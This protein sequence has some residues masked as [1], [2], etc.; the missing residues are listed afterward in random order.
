MPGTLIGAPGPDSRDRVS[1]A[2]H[3]RATRGAARRWRLPFI[4]AI[5][6]VAFVGL[7]AGLSTPGDTHAANDEVRILAGLPDSID[8]AGHGDLGSAAIVAQLF[9]TLT[10]HDADLVI[11]PA[12]ARGWDINDGGRQVVFRL[13]DGLTFSDGSPLTARDVVRSWRR[14]VDPAAPSPLA[15]LMADVV[16]AEAYLRGELADPERIGIRAEGNTVV[17]DLVRPAADFVSIVSSAPFAVVPPS[18]PGAGD[19]LSAR[20]FIGSGAYVL[21]AVA[22]DG[23]VL[24]ANPRYWAGEPAIATV[25]IVSDLGGR[26]LVT[27]F[28]DGDLDYTPI[29]E[30]DASWIRYN[31]ALGP[32][33]RSVPSLSLEFLG[34]DT[35]RPPFDDVRVRQA[36][37][38]AVNW[39]RIVELATPT[40]NVPATGMVPV[41]IPG[42]SDA[43]F[44]PAHDPDAARALL[45]EAGF[46]GGRGFPA[47][48]YLT[49]GSSYARAVLAEIERE[50]GIA[51]AFETMDFGPYFARLHADPPPIWSLGWVADYPGRND[52]LG[53]LLRSG[54]SNNY[55]RWSSAEF[56][57]ALEEALS[58]ADAATAGAAFDRAERIVQRDVPV[59]PLSY[60]TGWALARDGLLGATQNGLGILRMGGLAWAE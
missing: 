13:R 3:P 5:V 53:V 18:F 58:A 34:F 2:S 26:G 42:R 8:P 14:I 33:L 35:Q 7:A 27:A 36:F 16:G 23:L 49:G 28:E 22:L 46:P 43:D 10:A 52:F 31:A 24:V 37:G 55:G 30:F 57:A 47:V 15:S 11:R 59:V 29:S 19:P 45:A 60:G 9:E 41:G 4:A 48:T 54:A 40:S 32:Q 17:V 56:G 39:R 20:E 51:V 25:R 50:L 38:S 21:D 12:L 6:A 44:L 1:G